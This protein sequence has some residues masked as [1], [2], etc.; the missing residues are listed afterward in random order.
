MAKPKVSIKWEGVTQL[1]NTYKQCGVAL[2]DKSPD[3]KDILLPLCTAAMANAKNLAPL[4]TIANTKHKPGTL[5]RSIIA[6]RGPRTQRGIFMV[7]RKRIAPYA[8]FVEFGTSNMAAR[9]YF[10]PAMLAFASTYVSDITPG[11]KR[12]LEDTCQ[13]NAYKPSS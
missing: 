12:L 1:L 13:A 3:V 6:T 10:R 4:G 7:A 8:G 5:K 2:D 9:P 11:V